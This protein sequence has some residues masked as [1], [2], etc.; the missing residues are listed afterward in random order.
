VPRNPWEIV[1]GNG[2]VLDNQVVLLT[3]GFRGMRP[4]MVIG[5][6]TSVNCLLQRGLASQ[7]SI[8]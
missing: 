8:S 3:T 2:V 4:R 6:R 7:L 5:N 1:I